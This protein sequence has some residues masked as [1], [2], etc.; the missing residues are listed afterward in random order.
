MK[1]TKSN[2]PR[3]DKTISFLINSIL[4]LVAIKAFIH[5][6][7]YLRKLP[8]QIRSYE[9]L[10]V[11]TKE[12]PLAAPAE[13]DETQQ[14]S[15]KPTVTL[16]VEEPLLPPP[17]IQPLPPTDEVIELK[18]TI[19]PGPI[20]EKA[21]IEEVQDFDTTNLPQYY[22]WSKPELINGVVWY[23]FLGKD[24]YASIQCKS[25]QFEW[26]SNTKSALC[27]PNINK[28][29]PDHFIIKH[30]NDL[31]QILGSYPMISREELQKKYMTQINSVWG[32]EKNSKP[33][34]G[35]VGIP[36]S[37]LCFPNT[38]VVI[39]ESETDKDEANT[40]EKGLRG[41]LQRNRAPKK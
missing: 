36:L 22:G 20:V 8:D 37:L 26:E 40:A 23:T 28:S 7:G 34:E 15:V 25:G 32:F 21:E 27:F 9:S 19:E 12:K 4:I 31:Y 11:E 24:S 18:K 29:L 41:W 16:Q 35:K 17:V 10:S 30:G 5:A 3:F 38:E 6:P 1:N 14:M 2:K 33:G 13:V 39:K